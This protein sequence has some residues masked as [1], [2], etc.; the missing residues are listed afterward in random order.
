MTELHSILREGGPVM[1]ALVQR[2]ESLPADQAELRNWLFDWSAHLRVSRNL[3]PNTARNYVDRVVRFA[4]WLAAD[5]VDQAAALRNA[6]PVEVERWLQSLYVQERYSPQTRGL[7]LT[8]LRQFYR[9]AVKYGHCQSVATDGLQGPKRE[10]RVARKYTTKQLQKLFSGFDLERPIGCRDF[11][12][13]M[14]IYGTG[15]RREELAKQ[16]LSQLTLNTKGGRVQFE[17]KGARQRVV[18]FG[19]TVAEALRNWLAMRD[20]IPLTDPEHLW[21]GLSNACHGTPLTI[22]GLDGIVHRACKA[23]GIETVSGQFGLHRMRVTYATDLYDSGVDIETIRGLLGHESIETTRRYIDVSERRQKTRM[24]ED[25]FQT[26]IG[27][28]QKVPLWLQLRQNSNDPE[29]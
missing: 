23:G 10:K 29:S 11:A 18:S 6:G 20:R 12:I 5:S 27:K 3:S 19:A 26:V 16:R 7:S 28:Q 8:A 9:W 2:I 21:C 17:G 1:K 22:A 24:P 25:R 15:G 13:L 14:F 4:T